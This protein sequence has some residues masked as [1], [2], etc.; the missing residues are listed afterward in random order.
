MTPA[1]AR[2]THSELEQVREARQQ[3][4]LAYRVIGAT[5]AAFEARDGATYS[6]SARRLAASGKHVTAAGAGLDE[7]IGFEERQ[8]PGQVEPDPED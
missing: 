2:L 7:I 6:G 1:N 3:L 5:L 8:A 4:T